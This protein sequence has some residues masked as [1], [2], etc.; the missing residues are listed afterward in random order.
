MKTKDARKSAEAAKEDVFNPSVTGDVKTVSDLFAR[1]KANKEPQMRAWR[2]VEGAWN[3]WAA[4]RIGHV[5]CYAAQQR[6]P[7]RGG[8]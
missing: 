3:N 6:S 8:K 5:T 7:Y 4:K 1:Y 2:C